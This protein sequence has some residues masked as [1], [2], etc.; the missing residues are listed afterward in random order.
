MLILFFWVTQT[1][2]QNWIEEEDHITPA[3]LPFSMKYIHM[4]INLS[5]NNNS[6]VGISSVTLT[7][8]METIVMFRTVDFPQIHK[9]SQSIL[10]NL[11]R[12]LLE[13]ILFR[14]VNCH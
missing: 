13:I 7:Q 1:N 8:R 12:H 6:Y 2:T 9:R 14:L 11:L 5:V 10:E 3:E 4:H